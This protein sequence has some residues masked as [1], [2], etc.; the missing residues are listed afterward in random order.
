M[1]DTSQSAQSDIVQS[2]LR[3][4]ADMDT[5]AQQWTNTYEEIAELVM[6]QYVN[7]FRSAGMWKTQG[8][9][10]TE[11]QFD[12]AAGLAAAKFG[13]AMDSYLTPRLQKWHRL[14]SDIEALNRIPRVIRYFDDV[15]DRLFKQ[16]YMPKANFAGQIYEHWQGLGVF[17]TSVTF[18]DRR[19]GGGLR[20]KC[21]HIGEMGFQENHQGIIDKAH[22]KFRMSARQA[23]QKWGDKSPKVVRDA[24]EKNPEQK[25]TFIH[26]VRPRSDRDPNRIDYKGMEYASY[27]I[28][29]D[30]KELIDESGYATFPYAISRHTTAPGENRGRGPAM[31][32]L[33]SIKVLNEE[34]RVMLKVGQRNA[35]PVLLAHDD[36]VIG[37]VS[38]RPGFVNYG[39]VDGQGRK[40]VHALEGGNVSIGKEMMDD[41][42]HTINDAFLVTLFQI[43][44]ET[45]QMT[46]TEVL[47]RVKEKGA[48]IAPTMGRQQ[49]ECLG[50][51][52][53]RE[54]DL[55]QRQGLL[56]DMPP[57]LKEAGGTFHVIYDSPLSRA[58][59]AEEASGFMR[60]LETAINVSQATQDPSALDW[61]QVDTAMPEIMDIQAVPARW[62]STPDEVQAKR[63][64]RTQQQ[65]QQQLADS[66]PAI[67]SILKTTGSAA[68]GVGGAA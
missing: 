66:A 30:S 58:M 61:F 32:V 57:E 20:Y 51:L 14:R 64:S 59:Q 1:A 45:P 65:Q 17:G 53:E 23:V 37:N 39:A 68:P 55:M 34:K 8:Q 15:R 18:T 26:C 41:E 29:E 16:R 60:S 22:R 27:Y 9:Q 43:L 35:D 24:V 10:N 19:D 56:P 4:Q 52:I 67:A 40:L 5:E 11:R 42:R 50:P 38:L 36:G 62:I 25:F 21:V 48:L 33:P 7:T 6:P 2:V 13:A 44:V 54:L 47:E 46:A 31:Q 49:S 3:D 28:C 63:Q 12:P